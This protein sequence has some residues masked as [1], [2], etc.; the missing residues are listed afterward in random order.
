MLYAPIC[1]WPSPLPLSLSLGLC[2]HPQVF[3]NQ[4]LG[5]LTGIQCLHGSL[6]MESGTDTGGQ[7]VLKATLIFSYPE[8]YFL[9]F[10][11]YKP[12][13]VPRNLLWSLQCLVLKLSI[14]HAGMLL[15][16][17]LWTTLGPAPSWGH[18]SVFCLWLFSTCN[19]SGEERLTDFFLLS[20]Q[21]CL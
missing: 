11:N 4:P 13:E 2:R 7:G 17:S 20:F 3:M 9:G 1:L 5:V 12:L 19:W 6:R 14:V 18:D 21:L 10:P 15:W 16:A 8:C